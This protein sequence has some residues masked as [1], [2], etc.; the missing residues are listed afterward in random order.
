MIF[1][2]VNT[3]INSHY[4]IQICINHLLLPRYVIVSDL[5]RTDVTKYTVTCCH[6]TPWYNTQK[7]VCMCTHRKFISLLI[8]SYS[9]I[10]M[11]TAILINVHH[12]KSAK[13]N[14]TK[15]ALEFL[16]NESS[17][18]AKFQQTLGGIFQIH[19]T[20]R[21]IFDPFRQCY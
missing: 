3:P 7:C 13:W 9:T 2:C 6:A 8:L 5:K 16:M 20:G 14:K 18:W 21:L 15:D 17:R 4:E 19:W 11:S 1:N 12:H 10:N